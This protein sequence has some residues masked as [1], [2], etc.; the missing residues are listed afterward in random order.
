MFTKQFKNRSLS[1]ALLLL[2]VSSLSLS[3]LP[4]VCSG[5]CHSGSVNDGSAVAAGGDACDLAIDQSSNNAQCLSES[6]A[7]ASS[8]STVSVT[9]DCGFSD[10]TFQLLLIEKQRSNGLTGSFDRL[11]E[12]DVPRDRDLLGRSS[13]CLIQSLCTAA[14]TRSIPSYLRHASL[15]L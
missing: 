1:T 13:N 4:C 7:D 12:A 3:A 9:C 2:L 10:G 14:D 8:T 6:S 11:I 5:T 15:L